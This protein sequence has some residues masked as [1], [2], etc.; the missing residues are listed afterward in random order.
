MRFGFPSQ[1]ERVGVVVRLT[2]FVLHPGFARPTVPYGLPIRP[3]RGLGRRDI[4]AL[5]IAATMPQH[6]VITLPSCL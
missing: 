5:S 4:S 3:G 6:N 1:E 2:F